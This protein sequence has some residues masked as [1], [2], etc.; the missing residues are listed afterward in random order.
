MGG[1]GSAIVSDLFFTK[2]RFGGGRGVEGDG[3]S[4]FF[5]IL[6]IFWGEREGRWSDFF[7][8]HPNLNNKEKMFWE[9]RL[10]GRKG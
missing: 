7:T 6:N 3:V 9:G 5:K 4:D 8:L 1:R 10:R 2:I